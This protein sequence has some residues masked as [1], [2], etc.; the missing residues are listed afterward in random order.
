MFCTN[1]GNNVSAGASRC[2]TCGASAAASHT[3]VATGATT[4]PSASQ[5]GPVEFGKLVGRILGGRY[6]LNEFIG[7]GGMGEIYRARRTHIGDTVAVKVLRADV[8]SNEKTRQR[9]Y[10]EAR[11]AAM[12][13]HPNAVVIHDFGEDTDGL[14]YI[15]ME[16]LVGR[17]LR[18]TLAEEGALD[19]LRTYGIVRQAC[20]ALEAGHRSGIVHRDVKPDNIILLSHDED[21]DHVKILD[22]GIAKLRDK[23]LDTLSV[24]NNLTNVGTVIGTPN[25]MSPE[26]CQGEEAD[27]R[28]DLY[29]LGVVMYE[30]L[31]GV[32]PFIA[33]TPTGVAI[34]HV[35]EKPR[36]LRELQPDLP[37]EVEAGV[38]RALEKAPDARPQSMLELA[39]EFAA[40]LKQAGVTT[41]FER[42]KTTGQKTTRS[43]NLDTPRTDEV[44][45]TQRT[46]MMP[47]STPQS[48]TFKTSLTPASELATTNPQGE[49][50]L[51]EVLPNR[52]GEEFKTSVADPAGQPSFD[53]VF[54]E[55]PLTEVISRDEYKTMLPGEVPTDIFKTALT[56]EPSPISFETVITEAPPPRDPYATLIPPP[57]AGSGRADEA[58][59]E[60]FAPPTAETAPNKAQ[61]FQATELFEA[62]DTNA[63]PPAVT[64][65]PSRGKKGKQ[66]DKTK[67]KA[68]P[69]TAAASGKPGSAAKPAP[70]AIDLPTAIEPAP[71]V[72]KTGSQKVL[73][74]GIAAV[75][76]AGAIGAWAL[77]IKGNETPSAEKPLTTASP[78]ASVNPPASASLPAPP[79]GMVYIPGGEFK[80]GRE[81]GEENEKPMHTAIVAPFFMDRTEVTNE[82][83]ARFIEATGYLLPPSWKGQRYPAG[84]DKLPVTDVTWEDANEYAKW[85][86]K[87]LPTEEEWELA[88]RG[89]EGQLYPWGNSWQEDAANVAQAETEKR[90]LA[91]VGTY[92]R[93]Q[94]FYGVL[95]VIG[96]AW[97]WTASDYKGYNGTTLQT[98]EGYN[99]LKVIRG[100]SHGCLVKQ[101]TAT[102][103]RGW[104]GTRQDW[105]E[106][107]PPNYAQTSF[108]CAQDV[109][110]R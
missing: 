1:C 92:L 86:G 110:Q 39:R 53:T 72:T 43:V 23:A 5:S 102:Y 12:L 29:S 89:P 71:A 65:E 94:S 78:A 79:A 84:A 93:G 37:V 82:D 30:M 105:P 104:P 73:L 47:N 57:P 26:Q 106:G 11:A 96:N 8:V 15:V 10:R 101:A 87:R 7:S 17:S 21:H 19:P 107:V 98:P 64:A 91:P 16:L 81:D 68:Q 40:A 88:A 90:E 2:E 27:A 58:Q 44:Q 63:V 60:L 69:Q 4:S 3:G 31:T 95:D 61:V 51:T 62:R 36:P 49:Q 99:N 42:T 97:E 41:T 109:P 80:V 20:A 34:K 46:L 9:F 77:L 13:H 83:Y 100:C 45:G 54:T 24:E 67:D 18:Q 35:T 55:A 50:R 28:S 6:Q 74:V 38:L 33:K 70:A 22:F 48:D 75:L 32:M 52:G 85:A 108:R 103:R 25:Y 59:T 76:L 56:E 66:K 14:A